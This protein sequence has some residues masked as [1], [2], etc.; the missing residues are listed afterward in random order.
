MIFLHTDKQSSGI[1]KINSK[2]PGFK[3][4]IVKEIYELS[5]LLVLQDRSVQSVICSEGDHCEGLYI[6]QKGI[7]SGHMFNGSSEK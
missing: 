6:V 7:L 3:S 4:T 1:F 5:K 2:D